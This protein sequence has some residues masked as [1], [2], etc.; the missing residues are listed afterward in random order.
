[1]ICGFPSLP[2]L[3]LARLRCC[4]QRAHPLAYFKTQT[5]TPRRLLSWYCQQGPIF[6]DISDAETAWRKLFN[7]AAFRLFSVSSSL[8]ECFSLRTSHSSKRLSS[9]LHILVFFFSPLAAAF[10]V[11]YMREEASAT[12]TPDCVA[13]EIFA[14]HRYSS[15]SSISHE[16]SFVLSVSAFF[17]RQIPRLYPSAFSLSALPYSLILRQ[18]LVP[19]L[20]S[21]LSYLAL[22]FSYSRRHCCLTK[23]ELLSL[24][25]PQTRRFESLF[26]NECKTKTN[27]L[28]PRAY[29]AL[30]SLSFSRAVSMFAATSPNW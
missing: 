9:D 12:A 6:Y 24:P 25:R 29:L 27:R 5:E 4:L 20:A 18:S 26:I 22:I 14:A 19:L 1:M 13:T 8:L 15:Y 11:S 30:S 28:A 16:S 21:Q 3:F 10:P 23:R 7:S 17:V 2:P